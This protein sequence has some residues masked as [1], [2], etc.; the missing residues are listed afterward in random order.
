M[1][2]VCSQPDCLVNIGGQCQL[3]TTAFGAAGLEFTI[4]G[5]RVVKHKEI[6][7][8]PAG[9]IHADKGCLNRLMIVLDRHVEHTVVANLMT[10]L[11][12]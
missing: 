4:S 11:V 1:P 5:R 9:S 3:M 2:S 7:L 10:R 6:A 12:Q 8:V